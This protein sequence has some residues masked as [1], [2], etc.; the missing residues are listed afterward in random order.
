MPLGPIL[1]RD[2]VA[3]MKSPTS[4]RLAIVMCWAA[5]LSALLAAI[6]AL[7]PWSTVDGPFSDF[8]VEASN[9]RPEI[10]VLV[11]AAIGA[12]SAAGFAQW[13]QRKIGAL[14]L[15]AGLM[16]T[17]VG[18]I[19]LASGGGDVPDFMDTSLEPGLYMVLIGGV[20]LAVSAGYLTFKR[21]SS[22]SVA[23]SDEP[24]ISGDDIDG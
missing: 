3:F 10:T 14:G 5:G 20:L 2:T 17:L 13:R 11:S 15:L 9:D 18:A 19:N 21:Q 6:G 7:L 23:E 16:I 1:E 4:S 12:L 22:K 8:Y 24:L